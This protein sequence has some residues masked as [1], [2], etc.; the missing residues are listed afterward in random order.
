[1]ND[2]FARMKA[3]ADEIIDPYICRL[4]GYGAPGWDHCAGCCGGT[5]V[6]ISCR[7]DELMVEAAKAPLAA[8]R[9]RE[10]NPLPTVD[11]I[12]GILA[13]EEAK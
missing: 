2:L 12:I 7:E 4:P 3:M 9:H 8:V 6:V 5:G 1:M 11:D 13:E 10:L